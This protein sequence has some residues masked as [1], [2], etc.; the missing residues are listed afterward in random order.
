MPRYGITFRYFQLQCFIGKKTILCDSRIRREKCA[1]IGGKAQYQQVYVQIMFPWHNAR[2]KRKSYGEI[3]Q[4]S[5]TD[6][7]I[8][9]TSQ[10]PGDEMKLSENNCRK[11]ATQ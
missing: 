8:S 4:I 11:M 2:T 9:Y 10:G 6:R 1:V 5:F 3:W 7:I